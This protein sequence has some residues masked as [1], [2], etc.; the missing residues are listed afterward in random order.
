MVYLIL[1]I[2]FLV[3]ATGLLLVGNLLLSGKRSA[4]LILWTLWLLIFPLAGIPL[5]FLFGNDRIRKKR[6]HRYMQGTYSVE[7]EE[8]EPLRF[9]REN[10]GHDL[11]FRATA[12][13]VKH[14][15]SEMKTPRLLPNAST[16]YPALME[17]IEGARRQIHFQTFLW[18]DDAHGRAFR[19]ALIA[20][21]KRGVQVRVL[22]D[23]LGCLKL[24][25]VFFKPLVEAGGEFSWYLTVHPRRNRY[26]FNLRNHR[27]IQIIDGERAFVGGMN[28]GSEYDSQSS[29]GRWDDTQMEVRGPVVRQLQ[30]R[31]HDDWQF[32]TGQSYEDEDPP[33]E[34]ERLTHADRIPAIVVDSGPDHEESA[35]LKTFV[36]F[37]NAAKTR[38]DL[39]TPYFSPDA[40]MLLAIQLAAARGVRVRLM[41]P[42]KNEHQYMVDIGRVF[43]GDLLN[44]GVE[45]H[46]IHDRVHHSKVYLVDED[47]VFLGSPNLDHRSIR[48]NFEVAMLFRCPETMRQMDARFEEFF[49]KASR[50]EMEDVLARPL[51]ERLRQGVVKLFAPVL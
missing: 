31:F 25:E 32:A 1:I 13:V 6:L 42:T 43:F 2:L 5:Y 37:C 46:E 15:V 3:H 34:P 45:I 14:P 7:R 28:I 16:Y 39:F 22:A 21:A 11:L 41:I 10:S 9:F 35:F 12:E 18:R 40:S 47:T 38:L 17:A 36:L 26:F 44:A 27:K 29:I 33:M 24:K 8:A 50:V 4:S 49:A 19:D 20:A 23:E 48:L 51:S 30:Q